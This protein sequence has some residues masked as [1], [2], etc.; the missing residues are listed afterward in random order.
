MIRRYVL[1]L[2]LLGGLVFL[3]SCSD[4]D[5]SPMEPDN[6]EDPP[7]EPGPPFRV[8]ALGFNYAVFMWKSVEATEGDP[9]AVQIRVAEDSLSEAQW[10][11]HGT[12]FEQSFTRIIPD[13][14]RVF[15][16]DLVPMT[17][18]WA[19]R[20][21]MYEDSTWSPIG[22]WV[23]LETPAKP[24]KTPMVEVPGGPFVMG[25]DPGEGEGGFEE[26]ESVV[27]VPTF[28]IEQ[29]EVTNHQYWRF[30]SENGY[31]T[32]RFWSDEGWSWKNANNVRW[33]KGW[34][35]GTFRNGRQWPDHPVSG[36]SFY[37]AEAYSRWADRRLPKEDEWEKAARG[38][39]EVSGDPSQCDDIDDRDYPWGFPPANDRF[40]FMGS[41]DPYDPGP[42]PVMFYDGRTEG[43]F[44][45]RDSPGPYEY[46]DRKVYDLAGNVR[47]WTASRNAP[48]PY[49]D[50]DGR[51]EP[52]DP[53]V[54]RIMRG[55]SWND[56]A[57]RC[58]V[59]QRFWD[60]PEA[61]SF[62]T[63]FRCASNFGE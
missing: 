3:Q 10:E 36:V 25:S 63:G 54:P 13:S 55:G 41:G 8:L 57:A 38:G 34:T 5:G 18:Y 22:T 37:E 58:R 52:G 12:G 59:A 30:M 39:C 42:T 7:T 14:L 2:L 33:P 20:R 50:G 26:P 15:V 9:I 31:G 46:R 61:Q 48:Y 47:E 62:F 21:F 29:T 49:N 11:G 1:I 24:S 23:P 32:R 19:S 17:S 45:T 43:G 28:Y 27:E 44:E 4:D 35:A 51:E 6:G 53:D 56:S 40:N 16:E 60:F